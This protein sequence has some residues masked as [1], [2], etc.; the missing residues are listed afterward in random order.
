MT[1]LLPAPTGLSRPILVIE[2]NDEDYETLRRILQHLAFAAPISR[3]VD[4]EAAL[5]YL[6][7][8]GPSA[9]GGRAPSRPS[10]CWTSTC[11]AP[12]A[13]RCWHR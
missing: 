10:S 7:Q 1:A 13:E 12:M 9:G 3:C 6:H 11:R 5:D 4:G 2:D 8:Q